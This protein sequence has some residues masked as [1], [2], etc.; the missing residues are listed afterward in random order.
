ML[1]KQLALLIAFLICLAGVQAASLR[2]TI[3][4]EELQPAANTL[5]EI[6]SLPAQRYLARDGTYLFEIPS[7][8][9]TLTAQKE[10][11]TTTEE[12][13]IMT[14]GTY[15]YDLFLLPDSTDE[16]NLWND[17][18]QNIFDENTGWQ[19][20]QYVGLALVFAYALYRIIRTRIKYGP[21]WKFRKRVNQEQHKTLEQHQQELAQEPGYLEKA[22]EIIKKYDG[23]ITQKE[24][25][26]EMVYLSEAKVS[27]IVTELEHKGKIEKIKKGRGNV[28]I[29]KS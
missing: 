28:I 24:L 6:N 21:L 26:K 4:S 19:W 9:Y 7:G 3:Y 8:K 5:V 23:R 22:L 16:E 12:L 20:W 15:I 14:D 27:L 10:A 2:G 1:K 11:L 18:Q 29:V 13:E 17:T 25:R